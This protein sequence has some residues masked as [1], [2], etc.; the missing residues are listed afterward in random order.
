MFL[1][2]SIQK[3]Y[4]KIQKCCKGYPQQIRNLEISCCFV[5]LPKAADHPENQSPQQ[6]KPEEGQTV[7]MTTEEQYRP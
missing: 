1:C 5:H 2:L 4:T 7:G 6:E 3:P